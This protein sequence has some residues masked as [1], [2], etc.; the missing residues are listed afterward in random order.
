M[1]TCAVTDSGIERLAASKAAT[2]LE[3]LNV[4]QCVTLTDAGLKAIGDK[5]KSLRKLDLYGCSKLSGSAI[6]RTRSQLPSLKRL[7][8]EL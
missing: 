7:K 3:E 1:T 4:G 8:L 2:S 6:E 5:M